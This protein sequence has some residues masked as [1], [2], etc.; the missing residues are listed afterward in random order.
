MTNQKQIINGEFKGATQQ[1]VKDIR[2]M[3]EKYQIA[4]ESAHQVQT[5]KIEKLEVKTWIIIISLTVLA[6]EKLPSLVSMVM[7]A[8]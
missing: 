2:E 7:A 8:K 5:S 1:A 6:V 3:M 4:N